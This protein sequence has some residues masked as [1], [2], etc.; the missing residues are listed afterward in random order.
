MSN[1]GFLVASYNRGA[2]PFFFAKNFWTSFLVEIEVNRPK[3]K[4]ETS[5]SAPSEARRP[6]RRRLIQRRRCRDLPPLSSPVL[7]QATRPVSSMS[8]SLPTSSSR[9][10]QDL[11]PLWLERIKRM[12]RI[13]DNGQRKGNLK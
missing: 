11:D 8:A 4:A 13:F 1:P 7:P 9:S 12:E 6:T 2:A 3:K 5:G 10:S